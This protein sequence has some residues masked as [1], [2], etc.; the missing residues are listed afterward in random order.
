MRAILLV[1][2][3]D[4][5]VHG[6]RV[7]SSAQQ[8][9]SSPSTADQNPAEALTQLL[10]GSSAAAGFSPSG[11]QSSM[12]PSHRVPPALMGSSGWAS[13]TWNWGSAIGDA[14][15]E[16][17]RVRSALGDAKSRTA[18]IEAL[19]SGT[20][21]MFDAKLALAL[22]CQRARNFGYDDAGR[23]WED[24]MEAMA[25]CDFEAPAD[26]DDKLAEAINVRLENVGG[27]G[28][29]SSPQSAVAAALAHLGFV[30][31]GL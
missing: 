9:T 24:L 29:H 5:L 12:P 28:K 6:R 26:G 11:T 1:A 18:F 2:C 20:A 21:D 13:P 27:S 23:I 31:R 30:D 16:A 10:V 25:K 15:N 22:K 17:M 3:M 8:I 7:P 19:N 4:A 14:H